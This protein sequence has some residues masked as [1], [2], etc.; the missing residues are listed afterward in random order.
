MC[1]KSPTEK[2]TMERRV[3]VIILSVAPMK[4]T[5]KRN[6]YVVSKISMDYTREL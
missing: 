3:N 1:F 4:I 5:Q 2:Y 6:T